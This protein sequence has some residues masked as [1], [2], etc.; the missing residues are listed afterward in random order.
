MYFL[1]TIPDDLEPLGHVYAHNGIYLTGSMT[2]HN[3]FILSNE[4]TE[5]QEAR[6]EFERVRQSLYGQISMHAKKLGG[7]CVAGFSFTI[8][9]VDSYYLLLQIQGICGILA[10]SKDLPFIPFPAP[11][12]APVQH[13]SG[14]GKVNRV[15]EPADRFADLVDNQERISEGWQELK[16]QNDNYPDIGLEHQLEWL[17]KHQD[18]P[19]SPPQ[20][21]EPHM[22]SIRRVN[23]N[24][25]RESR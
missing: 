3:L 22:L 24:E 10:S 5:A 2:L 16:R 11:A 13:S 20:P 7:N 4:T 15:P 19:D 1:P 21:S 14:V 25:K 12:A 9:K 23:R 17:D 6:G 18:N 8:Q